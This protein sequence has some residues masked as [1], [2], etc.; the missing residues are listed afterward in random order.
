MSDTARPASI[1][2]DV[3]GPVMTG[4]SSSHTA[5]PT[6][7][8]KAVRELVGEDILRATIAF[9]EDGAYP[10]TY[11]GQRTD[12][13]F[14]GG[15]LGFGPEHEQ[16]VDALRIATERGR[17]YRFT[18]EPL[19]LPHPNAARIT[20]T[21]V[22]GRTQT[23]LTVSTGGG[24]FEIC[25]IDGHPVSI[26]GDFYEMT[27]Q[28]PDP[29]RQEELEAEAEVI[30]ARLTAADGPNGLFVHFSSESPFP[31]SLLKL[32]GAMDTEGECRV[33]I[34]E[35]ILPMGG[36]FKYDMPFMDAAGALNAAR[37]EKISAAEL[38][39]RYEAAASGASRNEIMERMKEIIRFMRASAETGL[40]GGLPKTGY[41]EPIAADMALNA[42]QTKLAD[43][44][45]MNR[46]MLIATAVMECNSAG[47][48]VVAAPTAGS[49]G[50]LPAAVLSVAESLGLSEEKQAEAMLAA[51][52]VGV[53][54]A[55][56]A[57]FAA[58]TCACQ[59]EIGSSTAMAAAAVSQLLGGTAEQSFAAAGLALQNVMGLICDPIGG[60]VELPCVN[61]NSMAASNAIVSANMVLCGFDPVIPLDEVI[62]AMRE[63]GKLLPSELRCTTRGGLCITPTSRA[64]QDELNRQ[65]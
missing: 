46:G 20:A 41:M 35:R 18:T 25:E 32:A 42:Q 1:F 26:R 11:K 12:M 40:R 56:Q 50:T 43:L 29:S 3:L 28:C 63:T 51:G 38:A 4:P 24:M 17:D 59:A 61:R 39:I 13:G 48:I 55:H 49:C 64:I 47:G 57:T 53:F 34:M 14:V 8:G 65:A 52:L 2:N 36:R 44:G 27:A 62:V 7:I 54:I 6:R 21:G 10:A 45:V 58:E 19:D 60:L 15:L 37:A 22:S 23:F 5:G 33:S 16:L 9:K 30:G 31:P